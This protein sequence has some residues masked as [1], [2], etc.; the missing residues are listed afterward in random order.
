MNHNLSSPTLCAIPAVTLLK[1]TN[2]FGNT[3][4]SSGDEPYYLGQPLL[5]ARGVSGKKKKIY[6]RS[7]AEPGSILFLK[8]Y[9]LK[10]PVLNQ[11]QGVLLV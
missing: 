10:A 9:F 4:P 8:F 11:S 5:V 3:I 2:I 6:V 1:T 7:S